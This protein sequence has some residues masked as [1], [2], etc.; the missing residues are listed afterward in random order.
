MDAVAVELDLVDPVC[1]ARR[2]LL[3]QGELR[4]NEGRG[5]PRLRMSLAGSERAFCGV[6]YL[7]KACPAFAEALGSPS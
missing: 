7:A 5:L 4:V 6:A 1:A 3:E 2:F